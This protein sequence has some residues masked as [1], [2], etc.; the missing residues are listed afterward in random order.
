MS[1]EVVASEIFAEVERIFAE[2]LERNEA[3]RPDQELFADLALD[4][5]QLLTLVVGLENRFRVILAEEDAGEVRTL[6][7]L[8][9]LVERRIA[10]A[11]G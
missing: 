7:D 9:R 3:L 11:A 2:E 1:G 4:S 10:E 5:L 6:G 8:V